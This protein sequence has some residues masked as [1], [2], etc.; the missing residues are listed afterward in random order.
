MSVS[1]NGSGLI[2]TELEKA[3]NALE[4]KPNKHFHWGLSTELEVIANNGQGTDHETKERIS[5]QLKRCLHLIHPDSEDS[6]FIRDNLLPLTYSNEELKTMKRESAQLSLALKLQGDTV[7]TR[8]S[9]N[10]QSELNPYIVGFYQVDGK[11]TPLYG[12]RTFSSLR[13]V[14]SSATFFGGHSSRKI[15]NLLPADFIQVTPNSI[16]KSKNWN[17]LPEE[18]RSHFSDGEILVTR[19]SDLYEMTQQDFEDGQSHQESLQ[20][21]LI[22]SKAS[23]QYFLLYYSDYN[24]EDNGRTAVLMQYVNKKLEPVIVNVDGEEL[25][26]ELKGCGTRKGM[27]GG[28]HYRTGR[29]VVTGDVSAG[30]AITELA[31]L[32]TRVGNSGPQ[33]GAAITFTSQEE[34]HSIFDPEAGKVVPY[35]QG[36]IIRFSPSTVRMSYTHSDVYPDIE[37][38]EY[39]DKTLRIYAEQFVELLFSDTS[40]LMDRSSHSEN[41]LMWGDDQVTFTDYS[42]QVSLHDSNFPVKD[43]DYGTIDFKKMV[44]FYVEMVKEIPGYIK[45]R[46][47]DKFYQYLEKAFL[48]QGISLDISKGANPKEATHEIWQNILAYKIYSERKAKGYYPAIL[49]DQILEKVKDD[50]GFHDI[51][52]FIKLEE[53]SKKQLRAIYGLLSEFEKSGTIL[54]LKSTDFEVAITSGSTSDILRAIDLIGKINLNDLP[55]KQADFLSAYNSLSFYLDIGYRVTDNIG[56]YFEH[57]LDILQSALNVCPEY[58]QDEIKT[59]IDQVQE[60]REHI[61][62]LLD[63][64]PEGFCELMDD[65]QKLKTLLE[66]DYFS[67][68]KI[69]KELTLVS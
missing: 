43:N 42:D 66:L 69:K 22:D 3:L 24:G 57:E 46:D 50:R 16:L 67:L 7:A 17:S 27:F 2:K 28:T 1:P 20:Q 33:A 56:P 37:A 26:V 14:D 63:N 13:N 19:D 40:K 38:P 55:S 18:L 10:Q 5:T 51:E 52:S 15:V 6:N 49:I 60:R 53:T 11:I 48:D 61:T 44:Q 35:E 4:S 65:Q 58:E 21:K 54:P 39:V 62:N 41:L 36:Y 12:P 45:D 34:S 25:I 29:D 8:V 47:L 23:N 68:P 64:D 31:Q 9:V 59:A 32:G 30:Q